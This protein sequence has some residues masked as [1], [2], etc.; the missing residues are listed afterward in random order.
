M[1]FA[2]YSRKSVYSDKSDSVDNQF[3]MAQEYAYTHFPGQVDDFLRYCDEDYTGANTNRPDLHRLMQ[4][5]RSGRIDA[6]IVYQLDRLSRDV[7]DFANIYD[8]LEE[9]KVHFI[10]VKENIDTTTPIGK[11]M[12]YVTVVF[13]QMERE[14]IAERVT[15]NLL[16][17]AKKG[18]WTSG[19]PPYG[20]VRKKITVNGR[21][22]VTI[23][24][25]PEAAA[26]VESV[27]D[28]FLNGR[29][30]LTSLEVHYKRIGFRTPNGAFFSSTQ[31]Y[32]LL[33]M[34]YCVEATPAVYDYYA[35]KGCIM[36]P[37]SPR[38]RWDGK[39]GVMV[40]GRST[41]RNR[42]HEL[43]PPDKWVVCLGVH[44]PF[45]SAE[46][47]LAVQARFSANRFDHTMK[48]FTPLLKGIV[49]C[50]CGHLLS[51]ARKKKKDGSVSSWYHCPRR[52]R[53]GSETCQMRQ[54][55]VEVLDNKVIEIFRSIECDPGLI[56]QYT[57]VA[58][59]VSIN[60]DALQKKISAREAQIRRL[61]TQLSYSSESSA[62]KYIVQEIEHIDSELRD[63][64]SELF[65]AAL[66]AREAQKKLSSSEE[67][68]KEIEVLMR[69]FDSFTYE[70]RNEIAKRVITKC[71]WDGETLFL[72]L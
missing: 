2:N 10:S 45:L 51:T 72:V 5:I 17:L 20:Y 15:D 55:K 36:D 70:E 61:T 49:R 50:S 69:N 38:E 18:F 22:H 65:S 32:K 31:I 30:T 56:R 9:H 34:P 68:A 67:R 57:S 3:R 14:T 60:T 12:M 19:N 7:R 6:L 63:L 42:R 24:P 37:G 71:V 8:T 48:Y 23:E 44:K 46:K 29:F 21:Q 59:P 26:F 39:H 25:V 66:M 35:S 41:E 52:M 40:Y 1:I 62:A 27:F 16:G 53:Y 47:W 4:D 33:T 28:T 43:Q 54:I 64:K 58:P 11:A 13:A